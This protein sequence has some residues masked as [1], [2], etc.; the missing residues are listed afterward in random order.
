MGDEDIAVTLTAVDINDPACPSWISLSYTWAFFVN[1]RE[2]RSA[3][4]DAITPPHISLNG[5]T[6][7]ITMN[8]WRGLDAILQQKE[9]GMGEG[10]P[11]W[12]RRIDYFWIDAI[13]INQ[14]DMDERSHQVSLMGRI[15]SRTVGVLVYL[16]PDI[17]DEGETE[18]FVE[19]FEK[20]A[21]ER[22]KEPGKKSKTSC[23]A[24]PFVNPYWTRMWIVQEVLLAPK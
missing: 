8:L 1:Y 6:T 4:T 12:A 2:Q 17:A 9:A 22:Q 21:S 16:A 24:K 7:S 20:L 10:M 14:T 19:D 23:I 13:C 18:S 15:Y 5:V 3:R 11:K